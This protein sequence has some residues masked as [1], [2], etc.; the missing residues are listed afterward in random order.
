M[1]FNQISNN[2]NIPV[3]AEHVDPIG[4]GS[5]TGHTIP[6]GIK[7]NG[8]SGSLINHSE[9]R[10]G[11]IFIEKSIERLRELNMESIV[12]AQNLD[13]AMRAALMNPDF[14]AIEPPELIGGNVSVTTQPE[15]IIEVVTEVKRISKDI[16][17]LSRIVKASAK[18]L[19]P[20]A[21]FSH[22]S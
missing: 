21:N 15:F 1:D 2:S 3:L 20:G 9:D 7:L 22:S 11:F 6:E 14:I 12:C 19:S 16:K 5:H 4:Y 17:I 18:V 8:A 13:V 10:A